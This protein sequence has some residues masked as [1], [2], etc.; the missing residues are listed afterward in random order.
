V[1][2]TKDPKLFPEGEFGVSFS[3]ISFFYFFWVAT[4][5]PLSFSGQVLMLL[6]YYGFEISL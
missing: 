6:G 2:K 5:P 4:P 1:P 3:F